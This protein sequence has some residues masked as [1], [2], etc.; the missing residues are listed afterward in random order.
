MQNFYAFQ[1]VFLASLY[2]VMV[3]AA[4]AVDKIVCTGAAEALFWTYLYD[5]IFIVKRL[6]RLKYSLAFSCALFFG[7]Y[8][9]FIEENVV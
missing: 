3:L 7:D 9:V 2:C 6:D 8:V 5:I 1:L 4:D